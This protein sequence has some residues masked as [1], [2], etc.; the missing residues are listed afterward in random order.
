MVSAPAGLEDATAPN[1]FTVGTG[2]PVPTIS[3]FTPASGPIGTQVTITGTTLL[4]SLGVPVTV[5]VPLQG[6]GTTAA[7]V[8]A[9]TPT[10]V[11]YVVPSTAATGKIT[12]SS[13]SGSVTSTTPF[14][15]VAATTYTISA[16]PAISSVIAGQSTTYTITSG[17]TN[18]FTGVAALSVSGL[19][20][21]LT[22]SFNP[23]SI[24]VGQQSILTITAPSGAAATTGTLAIAGNATV[25]G[26]PVSAGATATLNVQTVTT[27]FLGR[28]VVDN[29][30]NT[31]L[32]GVVVTMVGQNGAGSP[33]GCTG[34]ATS[35]GS[36]N[37]ALTNLPS[38]CLGPQ[39]IGFNGNSVTSPAGKYAGLQLVFTLVSNTVVV[40]PVLVHLP[41][42][43][44][45]ETFNVIQ[46]DTVD[47]TYAFTTV[48]WRLGDRLRGDLFSPNRTEPSRIRFRWR[49]L[50]C[51]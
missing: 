35:D 7:P 15:V 39:L 29:T 46:N 11:S 44:N 40:S 26:L 6:G 22:S 14:T 3:S 18:G 1:G 37:F 38:S 47:Q 41:R 25:Q 12:V 20:S 51:R 28:T 32:A 31:S 17:S 45:V 8:T 21:G 16:A 9:A 30:A 13:S 23:A 10:S 33:T 27:S 34:S 4:S 2:D 19:P 43:D 5:L 36:G 42:V 48:A 50:K 24:A 49:R